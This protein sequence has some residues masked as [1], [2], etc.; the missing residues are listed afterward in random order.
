MRESIEEIGSGIFFGAR[1]GAAALRE[2]AAYLPELPR[3]LSRMASRVLPALCVLTFIVTFVLIYG[4]YTFFSRLGAQP[5]F[6]LLIAILVFRFEGPFMVGLLYNATW[7]TLNTAEIASRKLHEE[8]DALT[9][10]GLD[11]MTELI[12]PRLVGAVIMGPLYTAAAI[13]A[14]YLAALAGT[15]AAGYGSWVVNKWTAEII[16]WT[17]VAYGL[18]FGTLMCV[19]QTVVSSHKALRSEP[20]PDGVRAAVTQTVVANLYLAF[21]VSLVMTVVLQATTWRIPA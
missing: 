20:S 4:G 1:A 12:A 13:L 19:F 3:L 7:T 6:G 8:V 10:M 18:L 15:W 2:P 16:S 11:P 9:V 17:D 14:A 21:V 5:Y